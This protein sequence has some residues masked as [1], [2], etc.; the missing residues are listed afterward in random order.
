[1]GLSTYLEFLL[2][3]VIR[4]A[5]SLVFL[6]GLVVAAVV[7]R[8]LGR[9]FAVS[10]WLAASTVA[11]LA[12]IA[13]VTLVPGT[14][15]WEFLRHPL[16]GDLEPRVCVAGGVRAAFAGLWSDFGGPLNVVLF[17]PAGLLLTLWSRRPVRVAVVLSVLSLTIEAVQVVIGRHC[18]AVDLV[19]NSLGAVL[20]AGAGAVA[21]VAAAR[22][23]AGVV[24]ANAR[25]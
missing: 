20:G 12:A 17:V 19:A 14:S 23:R 7:A 4:E 15:V 5:G 10:P 18:A 24:A 1:M 13:A 22:R 3:D 2:D 21:V 8:P 16:G 11:A 9:R 6:A 25:R